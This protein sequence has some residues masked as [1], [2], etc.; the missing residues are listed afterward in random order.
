MSEENKKGTPPPIDPK[1]MKEAQ[2]TPTPWYQRKETIIGLV[3]ALVVLIGVVGIGSVVATTITKGVITQRIENIQKEEYSYRLLNQASEYIVNGEQAIYLE[4]M[5]DQKIGKVK[6]G[7]IVWCENTAYVDET[8]ALWGQLANGWILIRDANQ[9]YASEN[10]LT[11]VDPNG[12]T[13]EIIENT[14]SYKDPSLSA[15]EAGELIADKKIEYDAVYEDL[16]GNEWYLLA[17]GAWVAKDDN[18][19]ATESETDTQEKDQEKGQAD[20]KDGE[21]IPTEFKALYTMKTRKEPNLDAERVGT[22]EENEKVMISELFDG[23]DDSV[24]GKLEDGN[25]VCMQDKDYTY[26]EETDQEGK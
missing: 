11:E 2:N 26:F 24:W 6:A 4:P 18:V 7:D 21:E 22:I 3:I 9:T 1:K 13:L 20:Q 16:A 23:E 5:S 10:V 19:K 12:G 14:M 8:E 25:W 15:D 17:N